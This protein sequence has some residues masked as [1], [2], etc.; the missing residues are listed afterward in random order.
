MG[1]I[2]ARVVK[3]AFVGLLSL[4]V[5][6]FSAFADGK[7]IAD[8]FPQEAIDA[9]SIGCTE[10]V[11][12]SLDPGPLSL[13]PQEIKPE[14]NFNGFKTIGHLVLTDPKTRPIAVSAVTDAIQKSDYHFLKLC[15]SPR[16]A[17]RVTAKGQV[18][19]FIICYQCQ[20]IA[21]YKKGVEIAMIGIPSDPRASQQATHR[22]G[23]SSR[24]ATA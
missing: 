6:H 13:V 17:L 9:L 14:E 23:D 16:H 20:G 11:L 5:F 8:R 3:W 19:D 10:F 18:F 7:T 4:T 2:A 12:Y 1:D 21:L 15:F 24:N 22:R